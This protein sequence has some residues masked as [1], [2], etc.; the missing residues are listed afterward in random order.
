MIIEVK[1][2]RK[3][4]HVS[5]ISGKNWNRIRGNV[6]RRLVE[7]TDVLTASEDPVVGREI[8]NASC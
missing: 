8:S 5:L 3:E 1:R 6:L 2:L 7:V 4:I